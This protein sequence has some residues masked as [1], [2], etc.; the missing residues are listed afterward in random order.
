MPSMSP[1]ESTIEEPSPYRLESAQV[2]KSAGQSRAYALEEAC[3]IGERHRRQPAVPTNLTGWRDFRATQDDLSRQCQRNRTLLLH[4]VSDRDLGQFR[5]LLHRAGLVASGRRRHVGEDRLNDA[6]QPASSKVRLGR[7]L[8]GSGQLRC[9]RHANRTRRLDEASLQDLVSMACYD[10][11]LLPS[12]IRF[13][14]HYGNRSRGHMS[15]LDCPAIGGLRSRCRVT[16]ATRL[17]VPMRRLVR[18]SRVRL[19]Q[20]RSLTSIAIAATCRDMSEYWWFISSMRS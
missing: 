1:V 19:T 17:D 12:R 15:E 6:M 16:D 18:P 4:P 20:L 11:V 3:S 7:S 10:E 5:N 8:R 9:E 14:I 13:R 2:A